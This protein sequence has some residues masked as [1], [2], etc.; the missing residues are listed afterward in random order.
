MA[1]QTVSADERRDAITLVPSDEAAPTFGGDADTE[2]AWNG[3]FEAIQNSESQ[4]KIRVAKVPTNEDGSPNLTSKGQVQLLTAPHDQYNFD[5]LCN[6]IRKDHMEPG[7]TM[8][9]RIMGFRD[10]V[11]G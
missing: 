3:W 4:G 8:C 2:Q 7:E 11:K 6:I 9:V 1:R 5:E 10:G